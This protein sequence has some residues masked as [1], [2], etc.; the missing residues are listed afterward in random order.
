M[1]TSRVVLNDRPSFLYNNVLEIY[2]LSLSLQPQPTSH[3]P[4]YILQVS[5]MC[6]VLSCL[7]CL[8]CSL[9]LEDPLPVTFHLE[10][11]KEFLRLNSI[12]PFSVSLVTTPIPS[13]P[14]FHR[15][16]HSSLNLTMLAS[17]T[18]SQCP[19][20][21]QP[22]M[23]LVPAHI[24]QPHAGMIWWPLSYLPLTCWPSP[25]L[26]IDWNSHG[27]PVDI[28][29]GQQE[30]TPLGPFMDEIPPF[31]KKLLRSSNKRSTNGLS[32]GQLQT[33]FP[34]CFSL[35]PCFTPP[36]SLYY[37]SLESF[38]NKVPLCMCLSWAPFSKKYKLTHCVYFGLDWIK[39]YEIVNI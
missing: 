16:N 14:S 5:Q 3:I 22:L 35:P 10:A 8:G 1:W 6:Y 31:V 27:H 15:I 12:L 28:C 37:C 23:Q 33:I 21:L 38:P 25:S 4:I 2:L 17:N 36:V 20:L 7:L 30:E 11:T 26:N 39:L 19:V 18:S 13:Q 32:S 29:L 24:N 34:Y 9:C